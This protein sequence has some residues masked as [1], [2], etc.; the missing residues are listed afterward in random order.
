MGSM[1]RIGQRRRKASLTAALLLLACTNAALGQS[2]PLAPDPEDAGELYLLDVHAGGLVLGE[3]IP[4][5]SL[6][7]N[8]FVEIGA[9]TASVEF[10]IDRRDQV[11]SGWFFSE[12][13]AFRWQMDTALVEIAGREPETVDAGRWFES[14]GEVFVA[15]DLLESWFG[16]EL[17]IDIREQVLTVSSDEALPFE[18]WRER[19]LAKY[20][21]RADQRFDP[22]VFVPDQYYWVTQPLVNVDTQVSARSDGN[23]RTSTGMTSIAAGMDLLKHS[24]SFSGTFSRSNGPTSRNETTRRL[25]VERFAETP[26]RP[27]FGDVHHYAFGDIFLTSPNLVTATNSGRGFGIDRYDASRTGNL[28]AVTITDNAPPGWEVEL[29]RNDTLIDFAT[30]GADG[31][32]VFADQ[33]IYFGENEFVARLYGPQGQT[34]EDRQTFFGGGIELDPGDYDYS[35]SHIDYTAN[36]LDGR[37]QNYATLP[38]S[39]A[40]DLRYSRAIS[41]DLE[42]GGGL[43]QV[44]LASRER[45]GAFD[46]QDYL[47]V[48]GRARLG[49]GVLVGE[50]VDQLS[51]GK[52]LSLEYLT[53]LGGK[54]FSF[55]HRIY[56]DYDSP[57][58]LL[59]EP[60]D[61]LT[62]I[63]AL[64]S[65]GPGD[66]SGYRAGVRRRE[67]RGGGSDY[68]LYG[69]IGS[70]LGAISLTN[71]LE[72]RISGAE[73]MALGIVRLAGRVRG[74]AIR[75]QVDYELD[76]RTPIRQISTSM[77][78]DVSP[79]LHNNLAVSRNFDGT[80]Q[81]FASDNLSV[82]VRNFDL[83]FG[84]TTDFDREWSVAAGISFA[85]GYDSRRREFMTDY[86]ALAHTGRATMNLFV[87]RNNNGVRDPGESPVN[88]VRY[89]EQA[90]T[91][92]MPGAV[93]LT[94]LPGE[95]AIQI[96]TSRFKFD[97]P[98]L[99]P[100]LKAY[101]L[102][103]HAGSDVELDIAV[104]MTGDVEG[105]VLGADGRPA[106]GIELRLLDPDLEMV[107]EARTEFDGYYSF[108]GVPGGAYVIAR[109]DETGRVIPL[110]SAALDAERGYVTVDDI[111]LEQSV[112]TETSP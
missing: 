63:S 3:S 50:A 99:V 6:G 40:T 9:L 34:R 82:R 67:L 30:V 83:S 25:T 98:F 105:T 87:D 70:R 97:D 23:D 17:E 44:G 94:A 76:G 111:V 81:A 86:R 33:D 10:P 11:W 92:S 85:F 59:A 89:R 54:T 49:P 38:A 42:I 107:G 101:E 4:A 41:S 103:T 36:L 61:A 20:Q 57:A 46:D 5:Y 78:W 69:R 37:V 8:F 7:E 27:I 104:V 62:E 64:G 109:I 24:V 21:Y 22:D 18:R 51:D 28:S 77:S 88:G 29:Y 110:Q 48:Y 56:D 73:R 108:S 55:A 32:Y 95:M 90:A 96:D 71:E 2:D 75:G 19:T 106:R 26:S 14:A 60:L 45:N 112:A 80:G 13:R 66:R 79:R 52:A 74:M 16:L 100:R 65:F 53:G 43:T 93:T 31:R 91:E 47:S 72:Y 68:R 35:V 84:A 58:T 15:A 12:E 102:Q 39:F 1:I